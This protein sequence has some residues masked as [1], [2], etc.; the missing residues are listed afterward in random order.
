MDL[1]TN[2]FIIFVHSII[3]LYIA[4][5]AFI[6]QNPYVFLGGSF[7]YYYHYPMLITGIVLLVSSV[8]ILF[9]FRWVLNVLGYIYFGFALMEIIKFGMVFTRIQG[10]FLIM[11][12]IK[13][14]FL[15]I[16]FCSISKTILSYRGK[17]EIIQIKL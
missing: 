16:L 17:R 6:Y 11:I 1:K 7:P 8:L 3:Y 14:I 5:Y 13:S 10:G 4:T 12:A 15:I 2:S 9:K